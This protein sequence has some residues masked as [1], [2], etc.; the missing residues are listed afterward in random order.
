[1]SEWQSKSD[2][3]INMAVARLE[4]LIINDV[5]SASMKAKSSGVLVNCITE[6]FEFNPCND[7][8]D[9]WPIIVENKICIT[10]GWCPGW[11]A[12]NKIGF[13]C[14]DGFVEIEDKNPLRAVMIV[15][16]EMNGVKP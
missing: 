3:E 11:A 4:H 12:S 9:A 8:S 16:L 15:Y 2:F 13:S 7:P 5:Q 10:H 1:M 6:G 14:A